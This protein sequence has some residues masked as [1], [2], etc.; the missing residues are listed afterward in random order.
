MAKDYYAILGVSK[1]ATD[2][3]LKKA[4]R[5]LAVKFHP[6]KNPDDK[7][8]EEKFKEINEPYEVVSDP[9]KRKKY[10]RFG[11]NWNRM[12]ESQFDSRGRSRGSSR[13][14]GQHYQYYE[15][16]FRDAFGEGADYS[17]LFSSFF[18][19][20]SG[21]GP[22]GK[23]KGQDMHGEITATI[24]EAHKGTARVFE[25]NREK[26]RI[27]LKPGAYDGLVI[28]LAGKGSPGRKGG[29][30]GDLYLTIRV[31]PH[32]QYQREGDHIK[33]TI[34]VD[35]FTAVLGGEKEISTLSGRIRTKIPA[36]TQPGKMLRLKGKGM[37][38]YNSPGL[39]GDLLLEI[40]VQVPDKLTDEQK[41][42]F[43]KLQSTFNKKGTFV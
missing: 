35:V 7:K 1:T 43:K 12:D 21:A 16:D 40:Q 10:D 15:G 9:E 38:V 18:R 30:K 39:F 22:G 20:G 37:P 13:P 3:E 26:I 19:E 41:E 23:M 29:T 5:K 4:F 32:A 17:D 8:G 14:S 6:D 36:G 2:D 33:Q 42:L 28:R 11:E 34:T 25:V 27:Q 24:E 31:L